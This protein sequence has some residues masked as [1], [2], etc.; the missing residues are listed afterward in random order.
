[1]KDMSKNEIIDSQIEEIMELVCDTLDEIPDKTIQ[2]SANPD[3]KDNARSVYLAWLNETIRQESPKWI[4][5]FCYH[6]PLPK[7][8]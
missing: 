3:D 2:W 6:P 1:M 7:H 5:Q 8:S 4:E